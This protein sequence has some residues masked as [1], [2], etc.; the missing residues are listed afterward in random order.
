M[1]PG[2]EKS[3]LFL[4]ELLRLPLVLVGLLLRLQKLVTKENH[5]ALVQLLVVIGTRLVELGIKENPLGL[6]K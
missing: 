6:L 3:K 4:L 5:L 1:L 2:L